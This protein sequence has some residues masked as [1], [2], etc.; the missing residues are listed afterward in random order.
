MYRVRDSIYSEGNIWCSYGILELLI[1]IEATDVSFS[2]LAPFIKRRESLF[3][4]M[5]W[6]AFW[7]GKRDP[8][9]WIQKK[10]KARKKD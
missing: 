4:K 5:P 10:P 7:D 8:E 1:A 3:R 6:R 9:A 2:W